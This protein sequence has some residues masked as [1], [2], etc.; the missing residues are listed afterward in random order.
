[1]TLRAH[2][3]AY[4]IYKSKTKPP[5]KRPSLRSSRFKHFD[6]QLLYQDIEL[7]FVIQENNKNRIQFLR[8]LIL[9]L[10]K[11]NTDFLMKL[12]R[13]GPRS[14]RQVSTIHT[15]S[16]LNNGIAYAETLENILL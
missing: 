15:L 5:L 10:K 13:M 7:A 11:S 16:L 14:S 4:N 3:K 12:Y 1:M 6:Q 2:R 9:K 8:G